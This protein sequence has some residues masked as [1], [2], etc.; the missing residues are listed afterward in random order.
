[1]HSGIFYLGLS[2]NFFVVSMTSTRQEKKEHTFGILIKFGDSDYSDYKLSNALT[3][4]GLQDI[5]YNN[6]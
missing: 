6:L 4:G 1:M 2:K 5:N 3:S